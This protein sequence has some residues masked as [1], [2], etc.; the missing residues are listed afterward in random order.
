M[1]FSPAKRASDRRKFVDPAH[2][3]RHPARAQEPKMKVLND[4]L[5]IFT[6][7]KN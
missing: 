5:A 4:S 2:A 1:D 3:H 6:I 7:L